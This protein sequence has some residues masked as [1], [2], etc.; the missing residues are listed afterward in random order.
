MVGVDNIWVD[1][2]DD[3]P[4][5]KREKGQRDD[6]GNEPAGDDVSQLLN[7]SLSFKNKHSRWSSR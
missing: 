2:S 3:N 5:D 7:R 1:I 6:D 4:D